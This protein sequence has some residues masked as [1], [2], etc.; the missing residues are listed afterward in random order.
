MDST[1]KTALIASAGVGII[2]VLTRRKT[3][4][5]NDSQQ[6]HNQPQGRIWLSQ[7]VLYG[8]GRRYQLTTEDLLWLG[9]A[10]IGEVSEKSSDWEEPGT[11]QGGA[12][13]AWA[14]A[15]NFMLLK[16]RKRID[17]QIGTVRPRFR[18]FLSLLKSYCQPI[19]P[20]WAD[21]NAGKCLERPE[22]CTP[23]RIARRQRMRTK[24]WDNL[25]SNVKRLVLL[26]ADGR[27][28][29]PIGEHVDWAAHQYSG[30]EIN[31]SGN[32]FGTPPRRK[33]NMV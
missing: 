28:Q 2:W 17:G 18:T 3:R 1:T 8:P 13:V 9:R 23:R 32:W 30:A 16:A 20:I 14:M 10:L 7:N 21:P 15:N 33:R 26:W 22:A 6:A 27:V 29:N 24:S 19:N 12:A 25:P 11:W 4:D 5:K 31:V